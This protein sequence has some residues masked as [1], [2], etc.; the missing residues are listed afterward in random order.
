AASAPA[1]ASPAPAAPAAPAT[2]PASATPAPAEAGTPAPVPDTAPPT[3][4]E[5][6]PAPAPRGPLSLTDVLAAWPQVLAQLEPVSR[7]S[8][9]LASGARPVAYA[10]DV[11]TLVFERAADL[12]AFK[13]LAGGKGPSEDLRG[14]ILAILGVRVK[15]V[16]RHE[17]APPG[18]GGSG[19]GGSPAPDA[20]PSAGDGPTG[21]SGGAGPA[22]SGGPGGSPIRGGTSG[23]AGA[24]PAS[25][26]RPGPAARSGVQASA[27]APV[28]EWAVA[29][30]P[31]DPQDASPSASLLAVD[32]EPE[33]AS[34]GAPAPVRT[35]AP[36][37]EGE[38]LADEAPLTAEEEEE[39]PPPTRADAPLPPRAPVTVE[40]PAPSRAPRSGGIERV[41]EA[42]VR[43]MLGATFVREEPYTP[44]TRFS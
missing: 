27:A 11:L 6:S 28:T 26:D 43:Q 1:P 20:S 44:P 16:A 7:S 2:S 4:V 35:L 36:P 12:A 37:R 22:S 32:D 17:P 24:S 3:V 19:L 15:Y 10:D 18:S 5:P 39:L 25:R 30:I 41:G 42:V 23:S 40:R 29:P 13:K 33:E 8:W 38:V 31:T 14:A 34:A 9:M 21:G